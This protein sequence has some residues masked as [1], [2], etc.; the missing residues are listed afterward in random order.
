MKNQNIKNDE[1]YTH[2]LLDLE[3]TKRQQILISKSILTK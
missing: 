3:N 1:D 2:L